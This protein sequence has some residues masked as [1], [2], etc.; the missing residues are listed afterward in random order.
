VVIRVAR[1]VELSAKVEKELRVARWLAE[2]DYP[3]VRVIDGITQPIV[4]DGRLVTFWQEI[5]GSGD[6]PSWTDL[7]TLLRRLHGLPDA[8]FELPT[9]DPFGMLPTRIAAAADSVRKDVDFLATRYEALR[10][11]YADLN[12]P[13]PF[14]LIHG[15]AHPGNLMFEGIQPVLLDLEVVAIGPQEWDLTPAALS[16]ERFGLPLAEYSAFAHAYGRDVRKWAG[17]PVLRDIR[18]LTMTTWLMQNVDE[19]ARIASEYAL[20]VA[21][22]REGDSERR[23][24]RF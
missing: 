15:D 19:D 20:R 4:V 2:V 17:W 23:W 21:S 6:Q 22:L 10:A 11:Q 3:A 5:R 16:V 13:S 7:A 14:G 12:F 1:S 18:E 24:H 9:F 8:P